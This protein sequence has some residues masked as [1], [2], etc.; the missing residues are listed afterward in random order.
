[1]EKDL[2]NNLKEYNLIQD[3]EESRLAVKKRYFQSFIEV[4]NDTDFF[5]SQKRIMAFK[6]FLSK[7]KDSSLQIK[8][9]TRANHAKMYL[10]EHAKEHSQAGL[11]PGTMITGSS[12]L[13]LSGLKSRL[14]INVILRD[15]YEHGKKL[16]DE[17]WESAID[18]VDE[19]S[20][21]EYEKHLLQKIWYE[22]KYTPYLFYVR[23]LAEYFSIHSN[24][25][26]QFPYQI[27]EKRFFV[28]EY[29]KDAIKRTLKILDEH[30]GVLISDVVG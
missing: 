30:D 10:F 8:K 4:F 13:T 26:I 7:L 1:M 16:F 29:Q 24:Q 28:L 21:P 22:K 5:D 12:N 2:N 6:T 20:F 25:E 9:T 3:L 23:V 27:T 11:N 14:E 19:N 18:I 15:E 17:L